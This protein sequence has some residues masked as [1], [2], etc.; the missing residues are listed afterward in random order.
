MTHPLRAP[1]WLWTMFG[2]CLVLT[3]CEADNPARPDAPKD[4]P[5]LEVAKKQEIGHNVFFEIQGKQ[6]RVLINSVVCLREGQLE[7]LLTRREKKEHEAIL[8]AD[9]DGRDIHKGLLAAGA[10]AGSPVSF[11]PK[12]VPATGSRIKVTLQYEQK[13]KQF[14]VP[15][16]QWVKNAKT[17]KDLD[18][19]WVFAGSRFVQNPFDPKAPDIYLA[20]DGDVICVSNFEG[21]LLDLPINSPK[22]NSELAFEANTE[23][24]PPKGTKVTIILE[25]LPDKK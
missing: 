1:G 2:L 8:A 15:A 4:T 20:N 18:V 9:A 24:I 13:G 17:M 5:K 10:A 7:Q 11:Q 19:D 6:R 22:D 21:A 14:T 16:Q 3:G 12:Y 23:R 25:P